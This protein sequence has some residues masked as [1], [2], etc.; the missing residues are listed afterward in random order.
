LASQLV[1]GLVDVKAGPGG[2]QQIIN[3]GTGEVVGTVTAEQAAAIE[4]TVARGKEFGTDIQGKVDGWISEWDSIQ[5]A[6]EETADLQEF[7]KSWFDRLSAKNEDGTYQIQT[8]PLEGLV[9]NL[10]L[11][12]MAIGELSSDDIINR[13]ESL[14]IVN[15]APVTTQE[16]KAMGELFATPGKVNQQNLGSIKS[17]MNKLNREQKRLDRAEGKVRSRLN[18]NYDSLEE[19]DRQYLRDVHGEWR[20]LTEDGVPY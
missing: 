11:G 8:G 12:N 16:L 2:I 4:A 10:G 9:A 17:F 3:K 20:P 6:R 5:T 18:S 15:L 7:S 1:T 13:L 14:Q 19:F